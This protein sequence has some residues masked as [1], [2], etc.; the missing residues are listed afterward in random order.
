[1]GQRKAPCAFEPHVKEILHPVRGAGR[2]HL[3]RHHRAHQGHFDLQAREGRAPCDLR[4]PLRRKCYTIAAEQSAIEVENHE[5]FGAKWSMFCRLKVRSY[6]LAANVAGTLKVAPLQILK[7]PVVLPHKFLDAE[8]FNLRVSDA[9]EITEI[10]DKLRW[11]RYQKGLRQRDAADYAGIDR[12][13]YIHYEEAGR[14][15]Y[16]KEHMEKL[17]ELFEVPLEDLLDDYNLFL[18]RGQGAQIKAIRQRLGLTQKAYATQLGVPL[19][20]FKRWE[21]GSVQIFKSTWEKYFKQS[22]ESCE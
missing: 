3:H 18:L 2:S 8:K 10:A 13:T 4:R 16:P 1:M 12:S 21:Q 17:A 14:D 9:S 11:Y 5:P 19:Q 20:K 15:F 7:F 6:V 22:L